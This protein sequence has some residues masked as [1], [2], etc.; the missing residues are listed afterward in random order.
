MKDEKNIFNQKVLYPVFI[1]C[2]ETPE[3]AGDEYWKSVMIDLAN[4]K[5]PKGIYIS[6]DAIYTTTNKNFAYFIPNED[7]L[8]LKSINDIFSD[9]K[10]I[11]VNCTGMTSSK[12]VNNR[13]SVIKKENI[14]TGWSDVKKKNIRE[15]YIL[16][17]VLSMRRHYKLSWKA[18][19]D[20]LSLIETGFL[21]KYLSNSDIKFYNKKIQ[22]I[23]GLKYDDSSGYFVYEDDRIGC[24]NERTLNIGN[25]DEVMEIEE[26]NGGEG[27]EGREEKEDNCNSSNGKKYLYYYWPR[28]VMNSNK[29][30]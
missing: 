13:Q 17:Y 6:N 27:R 4:G 24:R 8:S 16:Q 22:H 10:N 1:E 11:I 26:L 9:I 7:C 12:D 15:D 21:L 23:E 2:A 28:Y 25:E 5:C 29:A 20:L 14:I 3:C 19:Q 18:A 30:M